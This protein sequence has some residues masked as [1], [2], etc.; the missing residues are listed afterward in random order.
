MEK[1]DVPAVEDLLKR[2]LG[3]FQMAP[4]FDKAELEH[5]LLHDP[6]AAEQV[7]W[8]YV[9]EDQSSKKIIDFFSFYC[10]ESSVIGHKKHDNVRAAYLFYYATE[11]AFAKE[12]KGL[13]EKLNALINDALILAKKVFILSAISFSFTDHSQVQL[14]CVQRVN[15]A[16]QSSISRAAE[17]WCRRWPAALLSLQLQD[18]PYSRRN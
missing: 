5:W 13:K 11:T 9:V 6:N 2:Y 4:I 3:R 18:C 15:A 17:V 10:L 16:R 7:I 12:E 1:D 8:S 14:R